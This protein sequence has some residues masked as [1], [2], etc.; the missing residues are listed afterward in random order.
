VHCIRSSELIIN[1]SYVSRIIDLFYY[2]STYGSLI[3]YIRLNCLGWWC[4]LEAAGVC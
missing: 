1:A 3:S 4:Y 2:W